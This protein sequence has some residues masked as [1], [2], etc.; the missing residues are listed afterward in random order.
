MRIAAGKLDREIE[1]QRSS[2][3]YNSAN[4]PILAWTTLAFV[5]AQV[6]PLR[7]GE[8][9]RAGEK[10]ASKMSRFVVRHSEDWSDLSAQDRLVYEDRVYEIQ[11]VQ[12]LGR[13]VGFEITATARGEAP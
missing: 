13:R 11:S 5:A 9:L 3:T 7:D 12:E 1:L 8:R 4:E 2:T 10:L 6:T